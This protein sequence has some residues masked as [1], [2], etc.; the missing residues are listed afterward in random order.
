M[1]RNGIKKHAYRAT[2]YSFERTFGAMAPLKLPDEYNADIGFGFPDQLKDG[3]PNA[4][5]AYA[6]TETAQN[7]WGI[8]FDPG[9]VYEH[10]CLI[11]GTEDGAP[12]RDIR[13]SFKAT[14]I[15]GNKPVQ[16]GDPLQ[17]RRTAKYFDVDKV[18]GS[19]FEGVRSALYLN[20][21]KKRTITVG[22][23]WFWGIHLPSPGIFP[24]PKKYKWDSGTIGHDWVICGW[25]TVGGI[26]YL[27][28]K[29]WLGPAWGG[30]GY[31]LMSKDVFDKL[32]AVSGTFLYTQANLLAGQEPETVKLDIMELIL[33][34]YRRLLQNLGS[35]KV[36]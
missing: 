16:G 20:R 3:K 24:A 26:P 27:L 35:W 23:P 12:C 33:S 19:Y 4:C 28:C 17:Y 2:D 13:N 5:A 21:F 32:L 36:S 7:E 1:L 8:D 25:T 31:G 6:Q 22:T 30:N 14:E 15:Y 29:A 10:T 9:Y 11:E 34:L 18:N